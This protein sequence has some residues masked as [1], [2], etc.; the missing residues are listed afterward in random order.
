MK[1]SGCD[2]ISYGFESGTQR[3]L[4]YMK[5]GITIEQSKKAV[6][7]TKKVGIDMH[8]F[9]IINFPNETKGEIVKTINFAKKMPLKWFRLSLATPYPGTELYKICIKNNLVSKEQLKDWEKY[10]YLKEFYIYNPNISEKNL[11]NLLKK[12]NLILFMKISYIKIT[13]KKFWNRII[14]GDFHTIIHSLKYI[15]NLLTIQRR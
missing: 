9:F 12:S 6:E 7:I 15:K 2:E 1:K 10:N 5:K 3:I 13:Q 14:Q 8:G 4:D 11:K